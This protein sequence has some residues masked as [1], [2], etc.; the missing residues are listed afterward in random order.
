[1]AIDTER[2]RRS[3]NQLPPLTILPTV[4]SSIDSQDRMIV[5]WLYGGISPSV[6]VAESISS[7]IVLF[8]PSIRQMEFSQVSIEQVLKKTVSI[9]QME[10]GQVER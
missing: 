7:E 1:M 5:S 8:Y 10:S 2:K 4:D 9:K 6:S 3:V